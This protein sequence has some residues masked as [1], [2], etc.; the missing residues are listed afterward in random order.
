MIL[1]GIVNVLT[2]GNRNDEALFVRTKDCIIIIRFE[3]G[4][5]VL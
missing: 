4:V 1:F 5:T 3:N 2:V